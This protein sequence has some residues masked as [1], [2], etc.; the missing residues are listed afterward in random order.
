MHAMTT[1]AWLL[2]LALEGSRS[3]N[4]PLTASNSSRPWP[5]TNS[6]F[7]LENLK[8]F[9]IVCT[10]YVN[11]FA[12]T[13]YVFQ[14]LLIAN[15]HFCCAAKINAS[16]VE[17]QE[18]IKREMFLAVWSA[19]KSEI[20]NP[21]DML[22]VTFGS[23]RSNSKKLHCSSCWLTFM[24]RAAKSSYEASKASSGFFAQCLSLFR[25]FQ[26][27]SDDRLCNVAH[28]WL[29]Q[30]P[31]RDFI[32]LKDEQLQISKGFRLLIFVRLQE[33]WKT[34]SEA[35]NQHALCLR[36]HAASCWQKAV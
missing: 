23:V 36:A 11:T 6:A 10:I 31:L 16:S 27:Y 30:L 4:T 26:Q 7:A 1:S 8:T 12:M 3:R 17:E 34:L 24:L 22:C 13:E 32:H 21:F 33:T 18:G 2:Q 28:E 14:T 5:A 20:A 25:S 19:G 15:R 9:W 29:M 35:S